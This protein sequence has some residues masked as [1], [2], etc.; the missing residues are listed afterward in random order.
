MIEV[1]YLVVF[2]TSVLVFVLGAVWY[3]FIFG[4]MWTKIMGMENFSKEEMKK[5]EKEMVPGY[6]AEF[7]GTL[8]RVTVLTHTIALFTSLN[9]GFNAY[10]VAAWLWLGFIL[11]TV[12]SG[13]IWSQTKKKYWCHQIAITGGFG[14]ISFMIVAFIFSVWK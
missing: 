2:V 8:L 3:S 4:K 5:M 14:L 13:V 7:L 11:T 10:G 6:I 12:S 1:N 9:M